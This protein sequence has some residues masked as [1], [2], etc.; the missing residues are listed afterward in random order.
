MVLQDFGQAVVTEATSWSQMWTGWWWKGGTTCPSQL[1]Q[2]LPA[3]SPRGEISIGQFPWPPVSTAGS[4]RLLDEFLCSVD[5]CED[6]VSMCAVVKP[7]PPPLDVLLA[8][9]AG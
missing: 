3:F 6:I 2:K 8:Q 1:A 5:R 4:Y 7:Y 9:L